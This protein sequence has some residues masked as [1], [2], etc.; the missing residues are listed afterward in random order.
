MCFYLSKGI[1]ISAYTL[2]SVC[3][4]NSLHFILVHSD[5]FYFQMND[6]MGSVPIQFIKVMGLAKQTIVMLESN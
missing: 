3:F 6:A 5:Y 2:T 4:H 1:G